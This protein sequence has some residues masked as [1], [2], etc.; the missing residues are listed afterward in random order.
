M[1]FGFGED[2][3]LL[4]S[5]TRRFLTEHQ[6]LA[7]VRR[8]MEEPDL[9]D[10]D[11]WRQGA[12]LGWTAMLV[13]AEHEGGSVTDQ[14]L[15]DLVVLAEELGREL[16][17]GPFVPSN[18]VADAIARFGT[19]LQGKEHLPRIARGE[20]TCAWCLSGDGSP[21]RAAV[22]VSGDADRRRLAARRRGPLRPRRGRRH[23]AP[24]HGGGGGGRRHRQPAGAA[25]LG[26]PVR[27]GARPA[28]T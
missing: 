10:P 14:P 19:E 26:G 25:P 12:E 11:V 15:V 1:D 3:E 23:P 5:T 8:S 13:P 27:S 2:Q 16:N 17:P 6:P 4:R 22:E 7:E 9:F 18:V 24:R 20:A 21:E 28:S